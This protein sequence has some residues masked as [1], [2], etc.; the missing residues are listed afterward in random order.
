[1]NRKDTS[2]ILAVFIILTYSVSAF[3]LPVNVANLYGYATANT[4]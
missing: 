2:F 1:M 3:A 4:S